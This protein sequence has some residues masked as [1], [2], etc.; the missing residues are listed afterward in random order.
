MI[1][2]FPVLYITD[3]R[4][5]NFLQNCGLVCPLSTKKQPAP[6]PPIVKDDHERPESPSKRFNNS[7]KHPLNVYE[8]DRAKALERLR[9]V[10]RTWELNY[11]ES[12]SS[13]TG[14]TSSRV[15]FTSED[16]TFHVEDPE[17]SEALHEA[18]KSDFVQRQVDKER[19]E[20]LLAPIFAKTHR[21]KIFNALY[22]GDD[23]ASTA[24]SKNRTK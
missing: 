14:S 3:C 9:T 11:A 7:D 22:G 23:N 19:M 5:I 1:N 6:S 12:D 4:L 18:R 17:M 2:Q 20:R 15:Q 10:N 13:D 21:E 24:T 16:P 8:E